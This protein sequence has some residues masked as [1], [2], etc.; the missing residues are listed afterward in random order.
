MV[1]QLCKKLT[2]FVGWV[3]PGQFLQPFDDVAVVLCALIVK[4]K[5]R[6]LCGS[7]FAGP[8]DRFA[9]IAYQFFGY[10]PHGGRYQ[11]FLG[12]WCLKSCQSIARSAYVLLRRE[13]S[14]YIFLFLHIGH[15]Q[16]PVFGHP[17]PLCEPVRD[18]HPHGVCPY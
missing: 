17:Y 15:I 16:T 12:N 9:V 13:F 7:Q 10:L 5:L 1:S 8:A 14:S 18:E 6:F 4:V 11:P 2:K 3:L